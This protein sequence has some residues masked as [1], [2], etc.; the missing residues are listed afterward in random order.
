[1]PDLPALLSGGIIGGFIGA[2]LGGFAKF[3]W[4]QW[5]PGRLTWRRQQQIEREKFLAQFRDPAMRAIADLHN[6]THDILT[7]DDLGYLKRI[8]Q[9]SYYI[10]STT[11][12]IAQFFAWQEILRRKAAMLDYYKLM[13][14]LAAVGQSFSDGLPGLQI[15]YLE[16]REIG[17]CM[18]LTSSGPDGDTYTCTGYSDFKK[19]LEK[20]TPLCFST[21]QN[22]IREL[23]TDDQTKKRAIL[24]RLILI[25]HA[26]IDLMNFIDPQN[27]WATHNKTKILESETVLN[28]VP[29]TTGYSQSIYPNLQ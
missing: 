2:F 14:Y 25:Q 20:D 3:F 22:K 12:L 7:R 4:E 15:F 6:R 23:L 19:I 1:M 5:L 26:L 21:L 13:N 10:T 18:I 11:F 16:Q 27:H 17:E 28:K 8:G 9:E 29:A 24:K